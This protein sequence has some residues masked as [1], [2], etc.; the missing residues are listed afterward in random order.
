MYFQFH[1]S[2]LTCI[3]YCQENGDIAADGGLQRGVQ[4][5]FSVNERVVI[6]VSHLQ[7][8]FP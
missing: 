3:G 2:S 8:A 1:D 6:K 4:Y 5:P 7:I